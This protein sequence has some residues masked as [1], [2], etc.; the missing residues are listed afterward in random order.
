MK[1]APFPV[2]ELERLVAL[3]DAA[4]LDTPPEPEF[5]ELTKLAAA[6]CKTPIAL[7]SLV[8]RERQWFKSKVGLDATETPRELAFCA[9]A[10]LDS[11]VFYVPDAF[12]DERFADNP[13]VTN[14]PNVRFYAGAPLATS[15]GH[16]VGTLCVIDTEARELSEEQFVALRSLARQVASQ[17][18]LRRVNRRLS[19]LNRALV[20]RA[21]EV[22]AAREA[23][24]KAD[25]KAH[26]F[27]DI[28]EHSLAGIAAF[29]REAT[30]VFRL[31]YVN[32]ALLTLVP[33]GVDAMIGERLEDAMPFLLECGAPM[34]LEDVLRAGKPRS[35]EQSRILA[36]Q[37]RHLRIAV[38]PLPGEMVGIALDDIADRKVVERLKDEFVSTVSHELRTPLTSIRGA[39]GLLEGG[40]LGA[41]PVEAMEVVQIARSSTDRLVRLINDILDLEKIEAGKLELKPRPVDAR[42]LVARVLESMGPVAAEAKVELVADVRGLEE[43]SADSDRLE[44]VLTNLISNGIK[45][46]PEGGRVVVRVEPTATGRLRFSI[47]DRGA[48]IAEEDRVRLFARFEQL[49]P[50]SE[51]QSGG[52]GLGLAIS[53]ALVEQHGGVIGVSSTLGEGSTFWFELPSTAPASIGISASASSS[54]R[55]PGILLV[56]DD[57]DLARLLAR[58]IESEGY[59]VFHAAGVVEA[60]NLLAMLSIAAIVLDVHLPDGD[61]LDFF[62]RLRKNPRTENVPVMVVSGD[63]RSAH[64]YSRPL[65]VDW[66]TKPFDTSRLASS[67]RW[68]TRKKT[69]AR[70]LVVEDDAVFRGLLVRQLVTLGA[71]VVQASTGEEA[72]RLVRAA[73]PDLIILDVGLPRLDGFDVV[74][75]LRADGADD[76][77]LIVYTGR[78]ISAQDRELL[79]L[80]ITKFLT[81][82]RSSEADLLRQVRSLLNGLLQGGQP[83]DK[84]D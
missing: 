73:H 40:V 10:I 65:L 77:P 56:E 24:Q 71:E 84:H 17:I 44:Q 43:L 30:G 13:L 1:A 23:H 2:D 5:D 57:L 21:R 14:A 19:E 12:E 60:E 53:K 79:R 74:A 80:G 75:A 64:L 50:A 48:G 8:D 68:A 39:L 3:S 67:L 28:C 27:A 63:E 32:R 59:F 16:N 34:L 49:G 58:E 55:R 37:E 45:F 35:F 26:L 61:G 38:F 46:S 11:K 7:V 76:I 81:K 29:S 20:D 25:A 4:I 78:D 62:E 66:L 33:T 22:E 41:L 47:I 9:H 51:R 6:I 15:D 42:R 36:E 54:S 82:S 69:R 18:D 52:T 31:S 83:V 72:L 70:V